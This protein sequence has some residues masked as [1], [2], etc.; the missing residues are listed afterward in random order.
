MKFQMFK[1]HLR[2][3]WVTL[4]LGLP[5]IM[6]HFSHV[7]TNNVDV[8]MIGRVG[9][10]SLAAASFSI[11]IFAIFMIFMFGLNSVI[12]AMVAQN[13]G[14]GTPERSG[15]VL[16]HG[17][18]VSVITGMFCVVAI[19]LLLPFL[20]IFKQTPEVTALS[21]D[22]LRYLAWS[23]IPVTVL[24]S[25]SKFSEGV[26]KTKP[27][28]IISWLA[29]PFNVGFSWIFI[30]GKFGF[31]VMGLAGAG[32]G[33]LLARIVSTALMVFYVHWKK[34]YKPYDP[35]LA[36]QKFRMRLVVKIFGLG[37]PAAIQYVA[38]IG[39]FV[40]GAIV[41]GWFGAHA[42]AAHQVAMSLASSTFVVAL[43]FGFSTTV[44]AGEAYGRKDPRALW[45]IGVSSSFAVVFFMG[46]CGLTFI[47]LRHHLPYIYTN[48]P[49][50]IR[51][52][53]QFLLIAAFFQIFD[54]MQ[55]LGT[56]LLKGILDVRV[57]LLVS[58]FS[59]FVLGIPLI[60][61]LAVYFEIGPV[62]VWMSLLVM[63]GSAA[64]LQISR[65]F[66]LI[67]KLLDPGSSP[68]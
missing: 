59:H 28:M 46:L 15:I 52:A 37:L 38:E 30:F 44:R 56:S 45:N 12:S 33:T 43:S 39:A 62:G 25:Y 36:F 13:V 35:T 24:L 2:E 31:P 23:L 21:H 1:K 51:L 68:G 19:E 63:L 34:S 48:D 66:F 57:P 47:S 26:S 8:I 42:L 10:S 58:I 7:V 18:V 11:G 50:V 65:Y 22:Y 49:E 29:V 54:G 5:I 61:G 53:S 27:A 41:M 4:K 17:L 6:A 20:H 60:Y 16:R 14:A 32:L 55:S 40:I 3:N 67:R 64:V 9:A